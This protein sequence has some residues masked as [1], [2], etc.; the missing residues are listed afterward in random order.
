M[1]LVGPRPMMVSQRHLYHG[2][3]YYD[4]RPGITGFWQI[5]NRNESQFRDRVRFDDAYF[6]AMSLR[7][8]CAVISRT[9]SVVLRATGY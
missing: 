6:Q 4:L 8:D 2:Q 3:T 9:L 7:T 5:S 1:S